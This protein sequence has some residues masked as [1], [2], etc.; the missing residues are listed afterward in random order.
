MAEPKGGVYSITWQKKPLGFSIVMDTTGKNAYVSSIQNNLNVSKGLKLAAQIIE[1]NGKNQKD[2]KH[3]DILTAIKGAKLPITLKFQPRSF[4]N[5]PDDTGDLD[6]IPKVLTFKGAPASNA[7][8]VNGYFEL[9]HEKIN[10]KHV[11]QRKDDEENPILVWWWPKEK[12]N[13]TNSLWMIGRKSHV[14]KQGAYACV[15]SC[16]DIPT[17]IHKTW[18][19][20][21][22]DIRDFVDAKIIIDQSSVDN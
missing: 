8:R 18:K 22:Q 4:A 17:N 3:A 9:I 5:D 7:H 14:N 20:Y 2:K 15:A 1:I 11:W 13:L 10:D 19:A 16:E 21:D 12:S 6:E